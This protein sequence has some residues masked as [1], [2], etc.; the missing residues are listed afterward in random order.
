LQAT[1]I[2]R[3]ADAVVERM[4][5]LRDDRDLLDYEQ[6]AQRLSISTRTLRDMVR[7]RKIESVRVEGTRRFEPAAIDRYI[8]ERRER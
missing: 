8:A 4:R 6:V 2:D 7:E 1:D 5:D 3:L